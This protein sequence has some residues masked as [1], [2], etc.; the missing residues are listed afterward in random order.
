MVCSHTSMLFSVNISLV[1][2]SIKP[3]QQFH[4]GA[5]PSSC[6]S[7]VLS[8]KIGYYS[9]QG[10][11]TDPMVI[12]YHLVFEPVAPLGV[13][14]TVVYTL[15]TCHQYTK[16]TKAGTWTENNVLCS[17]SCFFGCWVS[18]LYLLLEP[19]F[20]LQV[21]LKGN[22]VVVCKLCSPVPKD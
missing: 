22:S 10:S 13:L 6:G 19:L 7:P 14:R 20:N 8:W 3:R 5:W 11:G 17:D 12:F 4:F 15:L 16:E 1:V 2:F 9:D 21:S 18:R